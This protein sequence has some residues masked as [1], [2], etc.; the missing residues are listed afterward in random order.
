M[1][2]TAIYKKDGDIR[3]KLSETMLYADKMTKPE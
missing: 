3:K 1:S 2:R